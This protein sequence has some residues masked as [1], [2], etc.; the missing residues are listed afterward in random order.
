MKM[1]EVSRVPSTFGGIEHADIYREPGE[2][3][4]RSKQVYM[5]S[6]VL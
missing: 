5:D 3:T 6:T 2:S 4:D 1:L